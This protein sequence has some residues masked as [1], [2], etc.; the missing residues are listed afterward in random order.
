MG[1]AVIANPH[2]KFD[3]SYVASGILGLT[4]KE[5]DGKLEP[6]QEYKLR[7][8]EYFSVK[9]EAMIMDYLPVIFVNEIQPAVGGGNYT[10]ATQSE[11][12]KTSMV[13][14]QASAYASAMNVSQ[15]ASNTIKKTLTG[16]KQASKVRVRDA[17]IEYFPQLADRKKG[18]QAGKEGF[19]E[20][21]AIG[22]GIVYFLLQNKVKDT[23]VL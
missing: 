13:I 21:D 5:E 7:L 20:V 10:V 11:L 8:V 9:A 17:V 2:D 23:S 19:D 1:W 18:W 14:F 3:P 12:A 15:I 6:Y 16:N 22:I 4:R